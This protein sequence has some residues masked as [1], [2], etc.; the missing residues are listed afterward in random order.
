MILFSGALLYGIGSRNL[1]AAPADDSPRS[2]SLRA[3]VARADSGNL[4]A[5][6][7][8]AGLI[9]KGSE[10]FEADS[11]LALELLRRSAEGG[12]GP[13]CNYLGYCYFIGNMGLTQ[14]PD[15]AIFWLERGAMGE[16]PDY[17]AMS[18]LGI[19][20]YFGEGGIRRDASKAA[21]WLGRAAEGGIA[22]A[23]EVLGEMYLRGVGVERDTAQGLALLEQA[24]IQGLYESGERMWEILR[25][26]LQTT[27]AD[28]LVEQAKQ[29][30]DKG[31]YPVSLGLLTSTA[32]G[33]TSYGKAMLGLSMMLGRGTSY[34]YVEGLRLLV[35]AAKEGDPSACYLVGETVA[36]FP[37]T[38]GVDGVTAEEWY[39][40]A[41]EGGVS[42]A[43]E[44]IDR[45]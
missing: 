29:Y 37:D 33:Q 26:Q 5:M 20:L 3:L 32:A 4:H 6:Y 25:Q 2:A 28:S 44:A 42:T 10:G 21:Y 9:E 34:N 30:S 35:E 19:M 38:P 18:N 12:Y 14:N 36:E 23:Q 13:A 11:V 45:L 1:P 40:R 16:N 43:E 7:A 17:K 8:L 24:A 22:A 15:S 39:E 27:D 31:I 41:R